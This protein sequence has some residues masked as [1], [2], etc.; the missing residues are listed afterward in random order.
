[1]AKKIVLT[2]PRNELASATEY[3]LI[4]LLVQYEADTAVV[5]LE[6]E[7]G[8]GHSVKISPAPAT[9]QAQAILALVAN[10]D[11]AGSIEEA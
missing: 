3:K 2:S 8:R 6:D 9:T 1:M 4:K 11:L 7:H 5:M 10:G